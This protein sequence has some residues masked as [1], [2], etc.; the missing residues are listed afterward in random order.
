MTSVS[1]YVVCTHVSALFGYSMHYVLSLI[2]VSLQV[3]ASSLQSL[4]LSEQVCVLLHDVQS[5]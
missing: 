4:P 2:S 5:V 1:V 3:A